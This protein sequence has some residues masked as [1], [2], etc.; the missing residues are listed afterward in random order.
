MR[1]PTAARGTVS[2]WYR[3]DTSNPTKYC[4]WYTAPGTGGH[5]VVTFIVTDGEFTTTASTD[6]F[7]NPTEVDDPFFASPRTEVEDPYLIA[8]RV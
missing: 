6:P 4:V 5:D 3:P 2:T 7:P 8:P 1:Q